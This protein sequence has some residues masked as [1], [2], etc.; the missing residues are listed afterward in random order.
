MKI[1]PKKCVSKFLN[2]KSTN[3]LIYIVIV[4][5]CNLVPFLK[6]YALGVKVNCRCTTFLI[7]AN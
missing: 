2:N 7:S 4:L 6:K 5:N 3:V 1:F